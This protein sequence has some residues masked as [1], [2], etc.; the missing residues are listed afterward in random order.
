MFVCVWISRMVEIEELRAGV[1]TLD[2]NP[3]REL[4]RNAAV[5]AEL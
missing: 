2:M 1:N 5:Q 4:S 3:E